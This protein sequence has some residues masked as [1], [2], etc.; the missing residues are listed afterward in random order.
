MC[1]IRP[2]E[3]RNVYCS[4]F[5]IKYRNIVITLIYCY[6]C[7]SYLSHKNTFKKTAN[8]YFLLAATDNI[9]TVFMPSP[10]TMTQFMLHKL[11]KLKIQK[12]QF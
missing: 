6:L 10:L 12:S 4:T 5:N 8:G 11:L 9:L 7:Y 3:K 1:E 2:V